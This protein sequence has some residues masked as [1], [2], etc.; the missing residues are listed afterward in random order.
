MRLTVE[1]V[2]LFMAL[3]PLPAAFAQSPT[4]ALLGRIQDA[5]G[6]IVPGVSITVKNLSANQLRNAVSGEDGEPVIPDLALGQYQVITEKPGFERLIETGLELQVDQTA[7]LDLKLNLGS[8]MQAVEAQAE[9]PLLNTENAG[10]GDVVVTQ[11]IIEA[12]LEGRDFTDLA[13]LIPGV[14]RQAQG[15]QGSAMAICRPPVT[16]PNTGGWPAGS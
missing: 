6:S 5:T 14:A 7:R 4:A 13:F 10:K 3:A 9:V 15:G 1:L 16:R 8:V 2:S 12:P 11:E